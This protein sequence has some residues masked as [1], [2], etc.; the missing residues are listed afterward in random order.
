MDMPLFQQTPTAPY[1]RSPPCV[2]IIVLPPPSTHTHSHTITYIYI[3]I[4]HAIQYCG[5]LLVT[6]CLTRG[7]LCR[8]Y[9]GEIQCKN[10]TTANKIL[11]RN[12]VLQ[13]D[14]SLAKTNK[15]TKEE[16][17][18]PPPPTPHTKKK[19]TPKK[20][21]NNQNKINI[22]NSNKKYFFI[23]TRTVLKVRIHPSLSE[24][25]LEKQT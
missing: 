25:Y 15:L 4:H 8:I 16:K 13:I 20:S 2:D 9:Q 12:K 17:Q 3:T 19:S 18:L 21:N 6:C 14:K 23:K 10:I 7:Q 22:Y 11:T 24:K 5:C 1:A